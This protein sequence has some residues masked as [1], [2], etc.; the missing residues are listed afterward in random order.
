MD[1]IRHRRIVAAVAVAGR[2]E[3]FIDLLCDGR[4]ISV[5]HIARSLHLGDQLLAVCRQRSFFLIGNDRL[6]SAVIRRRQ[7]NTRIGDGGLGRFFVGNLPVRIRLHRLV[8][9]SLIRV[10]LQHLRHI[11]LGSAD[12]CQ[13]VRIAVNNGLRHAVDLA[14]LFIGKR[15]LI[16]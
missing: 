14:Q 13:R 6:I 11:I 5:R 10:Q 15:N 4:N 12:L 7:R 16:L 2:E 1:G 9:F 8:H 3:I